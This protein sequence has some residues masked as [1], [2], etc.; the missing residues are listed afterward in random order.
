MNYA[1]SYR[2]TRAI[3][4]AL[5]LFAAIAMM[6]WAGRGGPPRR[7][8]VVGT[9]EEVFK[10]PAAGDAARISRVRMEDGREARVIV[11]VFAVQVGREIPLVIEVYRDGD[12]AVMFDAER[13]MES[14]G[15]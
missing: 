13:W 8:N 1:R 7:V 5:A 6:W 4:T 14:A 9:I 10:S 11:P 3:G 15:T 2:L 12:E